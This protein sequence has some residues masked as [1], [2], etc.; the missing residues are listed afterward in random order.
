MPDYT[1]SSMCGQAMRPHV[2]SQSRTEGRRVRSDGAGRT[3]RAVGPT[4]GLAASQMRQQ[5]VVVAVRADPEPD[6]VVAVTHTEGTVRE[7]DS[8]RED[9]PRRVDL[10]ESQAGWSGSCVNS[11]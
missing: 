5:L 11:R 9:G 10:L 4:P 6:H 7:T 2:G 3:L 8:H 1:S